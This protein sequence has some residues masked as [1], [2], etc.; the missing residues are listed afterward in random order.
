MDWL[1]YHHLLY[2]WTRDIDS[3]RVHGGGVRDTHRSTGL[4]PAG[5]R[6]AQARGYL[7][8]KLSFG[9]GSTAKGELDH[10][11]NSVCAVS[12]IARTDGC[13]SLRSTEIA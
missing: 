5:V 8:G 10:G 13:L 7:S 6:G 4:Q 11:N 9:V 2:F 1:N 12:A 3:G